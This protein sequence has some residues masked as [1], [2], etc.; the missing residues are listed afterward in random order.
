M[1][2]QLQIPGRCACLNLSYVDGFVIEKEMSSSSDEISAID[3][4]V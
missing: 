4:F 1:C 3:R 2:K